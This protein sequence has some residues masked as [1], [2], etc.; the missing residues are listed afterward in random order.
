[1]FNPITLIKLWD[2]KFSFRKLIFGG[3]PDKLI[4]NSDLKASVFD[5]LQIYIYFIVLFVAFVVIH[6][7]LSW[8]QQSRNILVRIKRHLIFNGLIRFL[9]VA[10]I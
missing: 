2:P 4:F 7:L 9:T 3:T 5:D 1:M 8:R 10:Y 6:V